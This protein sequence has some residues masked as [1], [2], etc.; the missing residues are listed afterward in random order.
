MPAFFYNFNHTKSTDIGVPCYVT[1]SSA[2]YY[3]SICA[4]EFVF[5]KQ[6]VGTHNV[7]Q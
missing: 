2:R 5:A 3:K 4:L 1:F 7:V 6:I